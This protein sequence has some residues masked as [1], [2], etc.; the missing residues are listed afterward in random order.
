MPDVWEDRDRSRVGALAAIVA[1]AGPRVVLLHGVGL[2]AEAWGAQIDALVS[3]GFEV[4]APDMPGH[5]QSAG[6]M[7]TTLAGYAARLAPCVD[8]PCLV[9][10][11]SMGAMLALHLAAALE[12]NVRGIACLNAVYDRSDTAREAVVARAAA[13]EGKAMADPTRTLQRWFDDTDCPE[14]AACDQWLREVS[15]AGYKA[16]Y[17]VFASATDPSDAALSGIGTPALFLTGAEDPNSTPA[18]SAALAQK[19]PNGRADAIPLAAH[20]LPMTHPEAVN[21]ALVALATAAL[22]RS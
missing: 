10:G 4:C 2:R 6:P 1:G 3:S 17:S 14:R 9:V 20:M 19:V 21:D 11:H 7:P 12:P 15:P 5:G 8:R 22:K 18:M 13:L 16:A